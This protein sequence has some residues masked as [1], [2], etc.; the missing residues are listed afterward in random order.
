MKVNSIVPV[1]LCGSVLLAAE[2]MAQESLSAKTNVQAQAVSLDALVAEALE[3][4][5][6]LNFYKAEIAVAKGERRQAGT[7]PNPEVSGDVGRKRVT[8][9]GLSAEGMAWSVSIQQP[10]EYPG[11]LALRKAVANRQIDLAELGYSQFQAAL[12]ARVRTV[13]Y[14]LGVA[15]Q[16][17]AAAQQVAQRGQELAEVIVQRDPAGITPLLETRIIEGSVIVAKRRAALAT[18]DAQIA[19][20]ELNQLRGAPLSS[21]VVVTS[22]E[23][24]FPEPVPVESLVM[25]ARTNNFEVR[26]RE[27]ELA[28]QGLRVDLSKNERWP[29]VTVGPFYSQEKAAE[30]ERVV[31]VGVS[32]PLPLWNRN[33]GNIEASKARA[34]QAEASFFMTLRQVERD[35]RERAAAYNAFVDQMS[36]WRTNALDQLREAAELG[37]RHYRLGSLPVATYVELQ[38]KYIEATEAILDTQREALES[39][40]QLELLTGVPTKPATATK[41]EEPK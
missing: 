38:E 24:K 29:T 4:N 9:G 32:M 11:R 5:P 14:G 39:R 25:M 35:V 2:S 40:Q 15:Q 41:K 37:D 7:Y 31:G 27:V 16:K 22:S 8:G 28:Q 36:F 3:K 1:M 23:L 6:E 19:L 17:S 13:G 33:I 18:R 30:T 10:F 34:Q 21:P 12:A 20:Y 26:S